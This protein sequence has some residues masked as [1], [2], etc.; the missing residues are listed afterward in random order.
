MGLNDNDGLKR[1]IGIPSLAATVV[2]NTIG[3]GIFALPAVVGIAM[4]ASGVLAYVLCGLIVI[5]IMLCY[6]EI[7]TKITES[8]GS[9]IY[10]EKAFG[11]LAGFIINWLFFFGWGVLGSAAIWNV[12]ADSLA[13]LFPVFLNPV[14]RGL[15]FFVLLGSLVIINV[16]GAKNSVKFVTYITV[17]KIVPLIAIAIFGISH[18]K[19]N[20]LHWDHL[21]TLQTT[22]SSVLA[23]F[24]AFVGFETSLSSSGEIKDPTKTI[25]R[26][27]FLGSITAYIIYIALQVVTQ[28]ILGTH[29]SAYKAAPLA[30]VAED[31]IG[32]VGA[33]ILVAAAVISCLGNESG[34]MLATPRLLYAGA[35][36]GLFPKFLAK[37]HP[38]YA[39]PY[40]AVI[41]YASL[42]FILSVSGGFKQLAILAS[43]TLLIIYLAVILAML[44]FRRQ[45]DPSAEKTFRIPGGILIPLIAIAAIIWLLTTLSGNEI[46]STAIFIAIVCVIYFIMRWFKK[47]D[48]TN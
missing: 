1:V 11:P 10:V 34:D 24:F 27:V 40:M 31:I 47:K 39:T 3:A 19:T 2:N 41:V 45:T 17:I 37:V 7:G 38:K 22:G 16:T 21:P 13:V 25:P 33:T 35:K 36:D 44:K 20:N 8:G 23:L 48:L 6:M 42:E 5:S 29:I 26:G 18:I 46:L 12:L 4:G 43:C 30:A 28:G 32:P 9:Y 14:M 15:L